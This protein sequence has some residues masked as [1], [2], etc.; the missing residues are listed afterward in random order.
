VHTFTY[1]IDYE[2]DVNHILAREI[3]FTTRFW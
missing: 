1:N 2:G 3:N